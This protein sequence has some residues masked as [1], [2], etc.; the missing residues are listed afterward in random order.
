[1]RIACSPFLLPLVL[2]GLVGCSNG[3]DSAIDSGLNGGED[4][5][6]VAPGF[7]SVQAEGST[8]GGS[9]ASSCEGYFPEVP[10][11][12]LTISQALYSAELRLDSADTLLWVTFED[13]EFCSDADRG[14]SAI[15]R[16]SWSAGEYNIY[17][18]TAEDG[19]ELDYTLTF[20]EG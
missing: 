6:T 10:Q 15:T 16:G 19:E 7:E 8:A 12:L 11:H 9:A 18:G 13:S 14:V 3:K 20:A 5:W 2:T 4:V 17:V 1:M